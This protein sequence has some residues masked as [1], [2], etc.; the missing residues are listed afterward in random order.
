MKILRYKCAVCGKISGGR[1]PKNGDGTLVFPRKH[2]NQNDTSGDYCKGCY[3]EAEW[4]EVK[5]K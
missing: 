5:I 4:V 2:Y 3:E 1:I